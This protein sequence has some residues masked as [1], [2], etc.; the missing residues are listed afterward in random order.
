MGLVIFYIAS[1][2]ITCYV[3]GYL[4]VP[5]RSDS[6]KLIKK[7][8][9]HI[10]YAYFLIS[11]YIFYCVF[12]DIGWA[13]NATLIFPF[14][15]GL[16][17]FFR[18]PVK[19][20]LNSFL[21]HKS[22]FKKFRLCS[23]P[24]VAIAAVFLL[25]GWPYLS[26][27][28][29]NYWHS[30]N[31]DM[32]DGL[33]GRDAYVENLIF[34]AHS[35]EKILLT[36]DLAWADFN[37]KVKTHVKRI[38][39]SS[40]YYRWYA[41]DEIRFQYSNL[42]FWSD[43]LSLR[44]GIDV[45][46][47]NAVF[48][49]ILMTI[50]VYFFGLLFFGQSS[51]LASISALASVGSVFYLGTFWSGHIG[52]LMYGAFAPIIAILILVPSEK[53]SIKSA[54]PWLLLMVIALLFTYP[55]A[56]Y[57]GLVFWAGYKILDSKFTFYC[58]EKI[59]NIKKRNHWK[60]VILWAIILAVFA[61]SVYEAW[62]LTAPYRFRQEEQFRSWG[63]T[64]TLGVIPMFWGFFI[65]TDI[66]NSPYLSRMGIAFGLGYSC[67]ALYFLGRYSDY[68]QKFVIYFLGIWFG[69]LAFFYLA[70]QDSY[71]IYKYLYV[72]FFVLICAIFSASSR[73][74]NLLG[75]VFML[76]FL[77]ANI[78]G[79]IVV[80]RGIKLLAI[81]N[82]QLEHDKI[83][84]FDRSILEKS[85]ID[86]PLTEAFPLRQALK[87]RGIYLQQDPRFADYFIVKKSQGDITGS[88]LGLVVYS[89]SI[90]EIKK[91]PEKDYL[92]MRTWFEPEVFPNDALLKS[93][94]F[95]WVG[96]RK[97][98]AVGIY[99]L[100]P[101]QIRGSGDSYL[102]LCAQGGP[103]AVGVSTL[104]IFDGS[105]KKL[106]T[107][108]LNGAHCTWLESAV[109]KNL[110]QPLIL[111]SGIKG[112]KLPLPEERILAYRL[113]NVG[114]TDKIYDQDTLNALNPKDDP[115]IGKALGLIQ[116]GNGW[117]APEAYDGENFR[118]GVDGATLIVAPGCKSHCKNVS[119]DFELGPSHGLPFGNLSVLNK[120]GKTVYTRELSDKRFHI[121][122][123][124]GAYER[125][126]FRTDSKQ[127][128]LTGPENRVL[129]FR[130]LNINI[131]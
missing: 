127:R 77:S 8:R 3:A 115:S 120:E 7:F 1:M 38:H 20:S 55:Q 68:R 54:F 34:D 10:G 95:R 90:L 2:A 86:L 84:H 96:T 24:L 61:L 50:G 128:T 103:S 53:S 130:I 46:V 31:A 74:K 43:F 59:A 109:V 113:F 80:A 27:G 5:T 117:G 9:M 35:S 97:D 93:L 26:T 40:E 21:P 123:P 107:L 124:I 47:I 106:S 69:G 29:G 82:S 56:L 111:R 99:V 104:E 92:M 122:F 101:D 116:F 79:D 87:A 126:S 65:S 58:V 110:P 125:Y 105:L 102:R 78:F 94:P 100:R 64:K 17:Y 91:A 23:Y 32:E 108:S 73:A 119:M 6:L 70:I 11:F 12:K 49:L 121:E 42:A 118:W 60:W 98:D 71:Y 4:L 16:L 14:F 67:L 18:Q 75:I 33:N 83:A 44:D 85:F 51:F 15:I 39:L 57:I 30:G 81:N 22:D 48:N 114:W 62:N 131:Q 41:G 28:V 89:G 66:F 45:V 72:H 25:A 76:I 129:D 36:K 63:V 52:S 13:T 19:I 112:N 37:Q 88:Q